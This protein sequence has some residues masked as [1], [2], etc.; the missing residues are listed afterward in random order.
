VRPGDAVWVATGLVVPGALPRGETDGPSGAAVLARALV[1]GLGAR[2]LL[3]AEAPVLPVL[4]AT[5][6][7]LARAER[8]ALP[9]R[10]ACRT[11][12]LPRR[13]QVAALWV[14]RR[15]RRPPKAVV[16]VEK[17]GPNAHGV[18]H[19][20]AGADVTAAQARMDVVFA[21]AR[22]RGILTVAVGDR[23]NEVGFGAAA[24]RLAAAGAIGTC[25]CPC[26]SSIACTV[27]AD[28]PV[29]AATSNWGA[30]GTAAALAVLA[31]DA[32]L[33]HGPAAET[34]MLEAGL[35]AGAVDGITRR[36]TLTV[37][38]LALERNLAVVRGLGTLARGLIGDGRG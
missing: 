32:R 27:A 31:G 13:A 28:R 18:M 36:S 30:Y 16:A 5:L 33:L 2:V 34:A 7:A 29:V 19:T 4:R 15:F 23:G 12:A 1:R 3:L 20:A 22:R 24:D 26:A 14:G 11:A 25:A 38:G 10:R 21:A 17:L 6:D 35:R 8:G 9:W 37:D